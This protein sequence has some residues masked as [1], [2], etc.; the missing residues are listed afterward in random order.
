MT[1]GQAFHWFDGD[2]A[3]AEIHRVLRTRGTLALLW[4]RRV[5][6]EPVNQAIDEL[7]APYRAAAPTHRWDS[8]RDAFA[9]TRLFGPLEEHQ[10][11]NEQ[12]LRKVGGGLYQADQ[13]PSLPSAAA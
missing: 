10:F 4:N 11:A 9:R 3:L 1:V 2:A 6:E 13:P 5:E 8:W 7:L 12:R